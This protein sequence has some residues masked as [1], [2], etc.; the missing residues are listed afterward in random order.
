MG[1]D[2]WGLG[3]GPPKFEVGYG[4]CIRSPN[5]S[6]SSVIGCVTKYELTKK[7]CH[8]GLFCSEVE[9]FRQEKGHI[10]YICY[11]I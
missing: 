11:I 9:V 10:L 2:L 6:L 4:P 8:E 7:R 1:G 3:D 5:I